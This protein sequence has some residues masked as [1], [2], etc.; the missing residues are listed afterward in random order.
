MT[1]IIL[2]FADLKKRGIVGNWVQL[3]R[4]QTF[5][6]FPLGKMLSPNVRGWPEHEV[7][8]WL[9][10]R[11]SERTAPQKGAARGK[12]ARATPEK[13]VSHEAWRSA[14][15]GANEAWRSAMRHVI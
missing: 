11:S 5:H 10:D 3:K 7:D 14:V 1:V 2:R 9:A 15:E 12:R 8:A 13:K 6:G 4:L